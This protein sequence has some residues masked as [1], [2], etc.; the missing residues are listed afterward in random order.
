M[1]IKG[2]IFNKAEADAIISDV[3][4]IIDDTAKKIM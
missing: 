1:S 2:K 4:A 3:L